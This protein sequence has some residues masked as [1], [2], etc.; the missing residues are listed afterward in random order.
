MKK[1]LTMMVCI[2]MCLCILTGCGKDAE[3]PDDGQ[4]MYVQ[5]ED[6]ATKTVKREYSESY[7]PF[8]GGYNVED[9]SRLGN[10]LL[11][12]GVNETES[13]IGLAEYAVDET[14]KTSISEAGI[15]YSC[16]AGDAFIRD[17]ASGGDGC[18]YVLL[19]SA[20][21]V[22]ITKYSPD[23]TAI[24]TMNV[25]N[26]DEDTTGIS[27][28]AD[29]DGKMVIVGLSYVYFLDWNG[30]PYNKQTIERASFTCATETSRGIVLSIYNF[31]LD[32][33]PFYAVD[34]SSGSISRLDITNPVNPAED[35]D[36]FKMVWGGS[37]SLCQGLD[38]EYIGNC[39]GS[40]V[41]FDF[42]TDSYEKLRQ[43]DDD[44][45]EIGA[46]CRLTDSTFICVRPNEEAMIILGTE[47]VPYTEKSPVTVA[48][49]GVD[50]GTY[51]NAA[52]NRSGV[53]E[54]QLIEY[55]GDE[56]ERFITE[57]LSGKSFDLVIFDD[58]VDTSSDYFEDLYP[59]IDSDADLSRESFLPNLLESMSV[60][61]ELHQLWDQTA[62]S[63]LVSKY[64]YVGDGVGLTPDSYLD[65]V[66][67]NDQ[68]KSVFSNFMSKEDILAQIAKVG[69]ST[70]VDRANA[71][72]SFDSRNFS[73]L[74]EWCSAAGSGI[75]E[76]SG[77]TSYEPYE[78]LLDPVY[79][80]KP[81]SD[82]YV[83]SWGDYMSY[84]G[85]PNGDMGYHYYSPFSGGGL[86]MA[87]PAASQN[88]EGAWEFI[89]GRLAMDAQLNLGEVS[90]LPVI[91]EAL[92]HMEEATSTERGK[93]AMHDLM[94]RIKYA[95]MFTD[96]EM[97]NIIVTSGYGYISGDKTLEETV[98]AIQSKASI[99]LAE[100]YG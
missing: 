43:W 91:T 3:M 83:E 17:I 20:S 5:T 89:K 27:I 42:D 26:F 14:G 16:N 39:G 78:Y 61:G 59:Y 36:G 13:V 49:V 52:N 41:Q 23:G 34:F 75:E 9:V 87:I 28:A 57:L 58:G 11:L 80:T 81:I 90:G 40:F 29:K 8:S 79:I 10:K 2:C 1:T 19:N 62:I 73:E 24:A 45:A 31:T 67:Q 88:K 64:S 50:C 21:D 15:I 86:S 98:S 85:F 97:R 37:M 68:V 25:E 84:V 72:C 99:Y 71:A 93:T 94:D 6:G 35:V 56:K 18:F 60:Q 74:L 66:A 69:A 38:G 7:Y 96:D 70:F 77:E 92:E 95:E 48:S 54:Y 12:L 76:G 82:T 53:Y 22:S 47:D 65:I 32:A 46:A 44:V 33:S 100:Q 30:T 63:T 51:I 55:T 4:Q